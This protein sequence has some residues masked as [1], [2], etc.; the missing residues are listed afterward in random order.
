VQAELCCKVKEKRR[1]YQTLGG[2]SF[3]GEV[4]SAGSGLRF[5]LEEAA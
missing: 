1:T 4:F 5:S 3:V 2:N